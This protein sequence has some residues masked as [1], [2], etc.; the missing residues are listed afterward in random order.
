MRHR[1]ALAAAFLLLKT[2]SV[3]A[4][5]LHAMAGAWYM[6]GVEDGTHAQIFFNDNPDGSFIKH[7]QD[8]TNCN[9]IKNWDETGSWTFD[10]NRYNTVTR[11]VDG[12]TVDAALPDYND[13][14]TVTTLDQDHS[15][16]FDT[17]TGVTWS[18]E[19]VSSTFA[20]PLTGG[21]TA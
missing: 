12:G 19:R 17:K 4:A 14:F 15:K 8:I 11:T 6:E 2:S 3:N 10:D 18:M 9:A 1:Q 20:M 13:A 16:M 21:C 5:D 7:I